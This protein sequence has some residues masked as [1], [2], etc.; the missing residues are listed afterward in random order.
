MT[1]EDLNQRFGRQQRLR[2]SEGPGGLIKADLEF[3]GAR[4]EL[5]LQGAHLTCYAPGPGRELLWM[6]NQA[7]YAPGTALR[8]G[9]PLCWPWFGAITDGSDRP[10]HGYAR[11][12][13]FRV[14]STR[15]DADATTICLELDNH[16]APWPDW[17]GKLRL[18][19]EVRLGDCLW[20]E[21]RTQ[22]LAS[23]PIV[24]SNALH[25]YLAISER[26]Q[27]RIPALTGLDYLDK[28]QSYR[29]VTQTDAVTIDAE[30]DRVYQKPPTVIELVD[31]HWKTMTTVESW[32][33]ANIVLWNPGPEKARAMADF[34][35]AGFE[36]MVCIEPA[37]ALDCAIELKPGESHRLGQTLRVDQIAEV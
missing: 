37:N 13:E 17:Q 20:M 8:G 3:N 9:I 36:H 10:Q 15:A 16:S 25:S 6:S 33:N 1:I 7:H 23:D 24:I 5:Y 21:L 27:V 12:T 18:E 4:A 26:E 29:P 28:P 35:N 30:I 19:F 22:N 34:D 32:G 2:F 31:D 14:T 11:T